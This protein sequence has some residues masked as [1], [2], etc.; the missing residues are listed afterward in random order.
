M[1]GFV[2]SVSVLLASKKPG[3][4]FKSVVLALDPSV[5]CTVPHSVSFVL[6]NPLVKTYLN[7][8]YIAGLNFNYSSL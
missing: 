6:K 4:C 5:G 1:P 3:V 8:Y 7:D 2:C